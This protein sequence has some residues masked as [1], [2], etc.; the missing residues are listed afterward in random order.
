MKI[1]ALVTLVARSE[2]AKDRRMAVRES[3]SCQEREERRQLAMDS[4]FRLASLM[5]WG[6][7]KE[8]RIAEEL[9]L[10]EC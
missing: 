7:M 2:N 3:W 5:A 8:D 10:V 4:Q 6:R 1:K 9:E